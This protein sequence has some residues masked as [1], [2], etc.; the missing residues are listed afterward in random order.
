M[1]KTTLPPAALMARIAFCWAAALFGLEKCV[2]V[3][4][5]AR[6]DAMKASSTSSSDSAMSAQS[7]R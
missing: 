1:S 3:T 6:A 5:T 7:E 4:T 2:P